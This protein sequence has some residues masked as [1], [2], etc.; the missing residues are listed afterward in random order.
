M[1]VTLAPRLSPSRWPI[2]APD[3]E[4]RSRVFRSD[5]AAVPDAVAFVMDALH[6]WHVGHLSR[7]ASHAV[8]AVA[9]WLLEHDRCPLG[10]VVTAWIDRP[11]VFVDLTDRS[12][13]LPRMGS[14]P[15]SEDQ[16]LYIAM[17]AFA[18]DWGAEATPLSRCLW[19]SL[20]A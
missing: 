4:Q 6:A 3:I 12:S 19:L 17:A 11:L 15:G 20:L 13:S 1:A 18:E 9:D 5:P 7:G 2:L 8:P 14:D 16:D 10:F